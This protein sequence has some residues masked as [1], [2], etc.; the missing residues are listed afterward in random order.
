MFYFQGN[1]RTPRPLSKEMPRHI[2]KIVGK[3]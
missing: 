3:K 1:R 2:T